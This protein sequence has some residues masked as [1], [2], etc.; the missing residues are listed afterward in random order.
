MPGAHLCPTVSP[1][2]VYVCCGVAA[3][4]KVLE[5]LDELA[6]LCRHTAKVL[7][8]EL[9]VGVSKALVKKLAEAFVYKVDR[10]RVSQSTEYTDVLQGLGLKVSE[11]TLEAA[12]KVIGSQYRIALA[13]ANPI[14]AMA[15][16]LAPPLLHVGLIR[17]QAGLMSI[18]CG[19]H[20][21]L[22]P[23]PGAWFFLSFFLV[24][25]AAVPCREGAW[26]PRWRGFLSFLSP[27]L[28]SGWRST[29][30]RRLPP[31]PSSST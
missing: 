16:P 2:H 20:L 26:L 4:S 10:S 5:K 24:S 12:I 3:E 11:L 15:C 14:L 21:S 23:R 8:E 28:S 6:D 22:A 27:R 17:S 18:T 7:A 25:M 31:Y 9:A 13:S 30:M 19:L 29:Q 1:Q